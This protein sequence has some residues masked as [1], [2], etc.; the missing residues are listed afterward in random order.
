MNNK[1]QKILLLIQI[2]GLIIQIIG[3]MLHDSSMFFAGISI[4]LI[5][6]AMIGDKT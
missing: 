6:M 5:A 3:F 1:R 4:Q 2:L